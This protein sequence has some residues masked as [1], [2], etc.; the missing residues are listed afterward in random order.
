[1]VLGV[2]QGSTAAGA[3]G[4]LVIVGSIIVTLLL[5]PTAMLSYWIMLAVTQ[6]FFVGVWHANSDASIPLVVTES[7][8]IALVLGLMISL[9]PILNYLKERPRLGVSICAYFLLVLI[10]VRSFDSASLAYL[11]NFLA[12]ISIAI[13]AAVVTREMS[14]NERVRYATQ[15]CLV[16][17]TVALV[18]SLA[19]VAMGSGGWRTFVNAASSGALSSLSESTSLFGIELARTGGVFVEPTNA[20]YVAALAV[21]ILILFTRPQR[22]E[23]GVG[24]IGLVGI[25]AGLVVM[26]LA[27]A[28][29][30][31]LMLAIAMVCMVLFR[32]RLR[33]SAAF[34]LGWFASFTMTAGYVLLA[35]GPSTFFRGLANPIVLVGG[36][37]TTFHLAGFLYGMGSLFGHGVGEGG[38]FNRISGQPWLPWLSTGSESSWGVLAYQVGLIGL[39]A[40]LM[41]L[42]SMG[43]HWGK[44]SAVVIC[45]WSAAAMFAEAMIGPQ[46]AGLAMV[47]AALLRVDQ[48][49]VPQE[50]VDP[51]TAGNIAHRGR[52]NGRVVSS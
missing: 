39:L 26:G 44:A 51:P 8:T 13:L 43:R 45:A 1:M 15:L 52:N 46:V 28:K 42:I 35:K 27:A 21:L 18:G 23:A 11:R 29:S 38:N 36:D 17:V 2:P 33:L 32:S 14:R 9:G 31:V 10:F 30:G 12:P 3:F 20:G 16:V 48:R 37:S 47:G 19:E 40:W 50:I 41:A 7:K 6:N 34:L 5:S 25:I 24:R 4:G 49:E 22:V